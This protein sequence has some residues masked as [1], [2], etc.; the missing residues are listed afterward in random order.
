MSGLMVRL[1]S[2]QELTIR[3]LTHKPLS[4][5]HKPF[6][7]GKG[8]ILCGVMRRENQKRREILRRCAPQNDTCVVWAKAK[9]DSSSLRSS[10]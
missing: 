4:S 10:E 5:D 3:A 1:R 9:K 8:F 7:R 6:L 2:P